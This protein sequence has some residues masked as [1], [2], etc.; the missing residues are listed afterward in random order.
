MRVRA[1][2][3]RAERAVAEP[4]SLS[5]SRRSIKTP[6]WGKPL[7]RQRTP[8]C[9]DKPSLKYIFLCG[10]LCSDLFFQSLR[11]IFFNPCAWFASDSDSKAV[12]TLT[13]VRD[14]SKQLK[15][16]GRSFTLDTSD[17]VAAAL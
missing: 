17:D 1:S 6:F 13:N 7:L 4:S 9:S 10:P 8:S 15:R 12:F 2:K 16:S 11:T 14:A 3:G 5:T